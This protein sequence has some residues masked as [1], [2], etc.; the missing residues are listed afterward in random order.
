MPKILKV[1][2]SE[3]IKITDWPSQVKRTPYDDATPVETFFKNSKER[4][5]STV[6]AICVA[7]SWTEKYEPIIG[8]EA[9][10]SV[11]AVPGEPNHIFRFTVIVK[12]GLVQPSG[13]AFGKAVR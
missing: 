9:D 13:S 4:T 1:A 7:N 6:R 3:S 5:E 12:Y 8:D 11:E 2:Y 10:F